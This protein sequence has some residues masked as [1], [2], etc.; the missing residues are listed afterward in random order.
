MR[1]SSFLFP[2]L[3]LAA[4]LHPQN[5]RA[6]QC[7]EIYFNKD[8][9]SFFPQFPFSSTSFA[10]IYGYNYA[11]INNDGNLD[12]VA[13]IRATE[14]STRLIVFNGDGQ[15][16]FQPGA[17][18]LI[19]SGQSAG[20]SG[21]KI[22]HL[23]NDST[24]DLVNF[25]SSA[26]VYFGNNN[27]T[28]AHQNSSQLFSIFP[29]CC[30]K[31]LDVFDV[32]GDG[33]KDILVTE[34]GPKSGNTFVRLHLAGENYAFPNADNFLIN[35][36]G[37]VLVEDFNNDGRKD[38]AATFSYSNFTIN[39]L[40]FYFNQGNGSFTPSQEINLGAVRKIKLAYD[41]DGDGWKDFVSAPFSPGEALVAVLYNNANQSFSAVNYP[42]TLNF[43]Q[44]SFELN[45]FDGDGRKDFA[46]LNE[47]GYNIYLRK[48]AGGF[49]RSYQ[50]IRTDASLIAD[51]NNDKKADILRLGT[52]YVFQT[53][54][55]QLYETE[56]FRRGRP[57][58]I[59]YIGNGQVNFA[60]WQP[61]TGRWT[62]NDAGFQPV[63]RTVFWGSGA[64]GD[65]PV[66]GDYD[67]DGVTDTA[68]FRQPSGT[69]Y[70]D[71][72]TRGTI[73]FQFGAMGDKPVPADFD[74]DFKTDFAVFRP[75]TGGWLI[76][77]S[78]TQRLSAVNFGSGD[79]KPVPA[80]FDGDGKAD[81][82]VFRP[83]NGTWSYLKSSDGA[84]ISAQF[85]QAGDIPQPTDVDGD[86]RADFSV[87]RPSTAVFYF[88]SSF[89]GRNSFVSRGQGGIPQ[90]T[91]G[92]F[93]NSFYTYRPS[94]GNWF[95]DSTYVIT[96]T[97]PNEIP[98]S[99]VLPV[100]N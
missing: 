84:A 39:V 44:A 96:Q 1:L 22:V 13:T 31:L 9:R 80:D 50:N 25:G 30:P 41:F 2:L 66:P 94:D 99:Y 69:W 70:V 92:F 87:F 89:D 86:G 4:V 62:Y 17:E 61:E 27:G 77:L 29:F 75:S 59:D 98:V 28:F 72:K 68:V 10:A 97:P 42:V 7:N 15:G 32:N 56:C 38:I 60:A 49:R 79:D 83:S 85:G 76:W 40:R 16:K 14:N 12:I 52:Y 53:H 5:F 8:A 47:R 73:V 54:A 21:M 100:G 6:A 78:R 64:L 95:G 19:T 67:G 91:S 46:A 20:S 26:S 82:A 3:L 33:R 74:G 23:N 35:G 90:P 37:S 88:A 11:D 93:L 55:F 65:I 57:D 51:F 24:L 45:D 48:R 81:A 58:T 63:N 36:A 34:T 18:T 43:A 71:T